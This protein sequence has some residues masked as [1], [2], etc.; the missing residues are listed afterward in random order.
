MAR[1]IYILLLALVASSLPFGCGGDGDGDSDADADSDGDADRDT[2]ADGDGDADVDGDVDAD[3]DADVDGDSPED[4][5]LDGDVDEDFDPDIDD[6]VDSDAESDTELTPCG[7]EGLACS[8]EIEI[9]VINSGWVRE[10]RCAPVPEGCREMRTC[11]CAGEDLCVDP[12]DACNDGHPTD[13]ELSCAC[14]TC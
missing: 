4:A 14:P 2:D 12:F 3:V 7:P 9:C 10:Y 6:D 5:G 1:L 8:A 13:N 11:A